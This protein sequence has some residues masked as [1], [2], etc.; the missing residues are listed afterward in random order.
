MWNIGINLFVIVVMVSFAV[1]VAQCFL[2]IYINFFYFLY[3]EVFLSCLLMER[4][5]ALAALNWLELSDHVVIVWFGSVSALR[6]WYSVPWRRLED[7]IV[8]IST[9][10]H[11]FDW[12]IILVFCVIIKFESNLLFC[13]NKR[14]LYSD[15][16]LL[17]RWWI[18]AEIINGFWIHIIIFFRYIFLWTHD[19]LFRR[20]RCWLVLAS[21]AAYS[22]ALAAALLI[23]FLYYRRKR[24]LAHS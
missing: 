3:M 14:S 20:K 13:V 8:G 12:C 1:K 17:W 10:A 7:A 6:N 24:N 15:E 21:P 4:M 23:L 9:L 19:K 22:I 16:Q 18:K 11:L 2:A 5:I